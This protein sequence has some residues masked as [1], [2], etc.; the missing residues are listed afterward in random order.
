MNT[1]SLKISIAQR[2]LSIG[3]DFVLEQINQLLMKKNIIGYT[4]DGKAVTEEDYVSGLDRI[5]S[6][7]D[8][9]TAQL[10]S[11][12]DVKNRIINANNLV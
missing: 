11:S 6:E 9:G 10:F 3:D 2:I 5:N 12:K 4:A 7:I 1:E 8:N